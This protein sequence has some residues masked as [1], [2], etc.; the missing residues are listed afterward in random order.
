M[1]FDPLGDA[2]GFVEYVQ[3]EQGK[4]QIYRS[5]LDVLVNLGI[6]AAGAIIFYWLLSGQQ[7]T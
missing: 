2:V 6:T 4:K 1:K 3:G 5:I 7:Q